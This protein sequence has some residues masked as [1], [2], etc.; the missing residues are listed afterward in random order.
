VGGPFANSRPMMTSVRCAQLGG[1]RRGLELSLAFSVTNDRLWVP[2]SS[3]GQV[4]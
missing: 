1:S 3:D 4:K 2:V